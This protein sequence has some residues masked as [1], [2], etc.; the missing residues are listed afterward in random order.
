MNIQEGKILTVEA[1]IDA[2]IEKVWE[3]WTNPVHIKNWNQAS[4]DWHTTHS[5]NEFRV[6]GKFLSRMEAKDGT[7]GFD[8]WGT[9]DVITPKEYIEYTMGDGRKVNITFQEE[10]AKTKLVE[11]FEPEQ[12]NPLEM[13]QAGWQAILD[14]FK[15]YTETN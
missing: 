6:G 13:Q 3:Y 4:A 15:Q 11:K 5:E 8:F 7:A 10:A 2:P 14:N 9:Y 1:L 12:T